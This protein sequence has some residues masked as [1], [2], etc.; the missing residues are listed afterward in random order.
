MASDVAAA[1]G[2]G[3]T[4]TGAAIPGACFYTS[5]DG[6]VRV[7]AYAQAYQDAASAN[8]VSAA[9]LAASLNLSGLGTAKPLSGIGDKA[10]EYVGNSSTGNSILILIIKSNVSLLIDVMPAPSASIVEQLARAAA[11]HLH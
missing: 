5:A 11:G 9:Q 10:V 7:I 8:A 1:L 2:S 6:T 3:F 4:S